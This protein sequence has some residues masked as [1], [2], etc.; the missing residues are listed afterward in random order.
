MRFVIL[1]VSF[2][3]CLPLSGYW[4]DHS[5]RSTNFELSRMRAQCYIK[6]SQTQ[7][8]LN[9]WSFRFSGLKID[10]NNWLFV[11]AALLQVIWCFLLGRANVQCTRARAQRKSSVIFAGSLVLP[12]PVLVKPVALHAECP[13][14][15]QFSVNSLSL[16]NNEKVV[17]CAPGAGFAIV[18]ILSLASL[19]LSSKKQRTATPQGWNLG[20]ISAILLRHAEKPERVHT[21]TTLNFENPATNTKKPQRTE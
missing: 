1:P 6:I 21:H 2:C 3:F 19:G 13:L 11:F 12:K 16:C 7:G 20:Y 14:F 15:P 5:L 4:S 18:R 10:E 8:V 9:P 17:A